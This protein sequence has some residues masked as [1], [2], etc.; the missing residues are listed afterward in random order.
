MSK[1]IK[2]PKNKQQELKQSELYRG[3]DRCEVLVFVSVSQQVGCS[4][5]HKTPTGFRSLLLRKGLTFAR[6][7][8]FKNP[9]SSYVFLEV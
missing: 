2:C 3:L 1:A 5:L 7:H 4:I 8:R 6:R 9:A